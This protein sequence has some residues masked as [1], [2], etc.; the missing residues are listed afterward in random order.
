MKKNNSKEII[1]KEI[2]AKRN[3]MDENKINSMS[4]EVF[5]T[6]EILGVFQESQYIFIYKSL[7]GEVST[8]NF[9]D[10]WI[11]SRHLFCPCIIDDQ[12][13]F[14]RIHR[15]TQYTISKFGVSEPIGDDCIDFSKIDLIIVPGVAFDIHKNRLG[16]GKGYYDRF[17]QNKKVP[18]IGVCFDY[19]LLEHVPTDENDIK[20][21]YI[22]S[23][24]NLIW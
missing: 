1:R 12:I 2:K 5:D 22:I 9:I 19:Q 23:E 16:F 11:D 14:R 20:M 3:E 17:L 4:E 10:K 8:D 24:N 21:D 7:I 15:E 18:K 13:K 6:L